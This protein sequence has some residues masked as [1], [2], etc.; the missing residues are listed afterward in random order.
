MN[1]EDISEKIDLLYSSAGNKLRESAGDFNDLMKWVK[2]VEELT[3]NE[4]TV[5]L[6]SIF[7][8]Q[9]L[10]GG[11]GQ[12]F[13]NSY[14]IFGY[15]TA[16][17]LEA[18]NATRTSSI[19]RNALSIVNVNKLQGNDFKKYIWNTILDDDLL[20]SLDELDAQLYNDD[21]ADDLV[22]LIGEYISK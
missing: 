9:T 6:I 22:Y 7:D 12:Y 10:N 16:E 15:E 8:M 14:G 11:L 18:I 2:G 5:Y 20:D 17:I 4:R 13:D 1:R 19:L 21:L 3:E